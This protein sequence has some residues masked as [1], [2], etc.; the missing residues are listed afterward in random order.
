MAS[1]VMPPSWHY[2]TQTYLSIY[3]VSSSIIGNS[4]QIIFITLFSTGAQQRCCW[5]IMISQKPFFP[6][7]YRHFFLTFLHPILLCTAAGDA[8]LSLM[9]AVITGDD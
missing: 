8:P 1:W 5:T 2:P 3:L 9:S 6:E 4:S 7:P